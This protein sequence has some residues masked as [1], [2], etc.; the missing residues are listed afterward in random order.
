MTMNMS[1][2]GWTRE[3]KILALIRLPWDVRITKEEDGSLFAQIA[4]ISD[5]VADGENERELAVD[6]WESLYASLAVRLDRGDP[7]PLPEGH[8]LPWATSGSPR[9]P[10]RETGVTAHLVRKAYG[11]AQPV[12]EAAAG[13]FVLAGAA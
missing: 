4:E 5:A 9:R 13:D 8:G 10:Q 7:V 2:Q 6:L 3:D 1:E 12:P 11:R